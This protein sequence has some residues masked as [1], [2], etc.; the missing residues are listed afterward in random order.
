[1]VEEESIKSTK[2]ISKKVKRKNDYQED[3]EIEF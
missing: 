2:A 3:D 1:M